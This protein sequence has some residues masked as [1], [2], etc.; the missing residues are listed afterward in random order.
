MLAFTFMTLFLSQSPC[1]IRSLAHVFIKGLPSTRA[2]QVKRVF[3]PPSAWLGR[4]LSTTLVVNYGHT[5]LTC[6]LL[7]HN[8]LFDA[9]RH[10]LYYTRRLSWSPA[11]IRRTFTAIKPE[12]WLGCP[13]FGGGIHNIFNWRRKLYIGHQSAGKTH[14]CG[15]LLPITGI[16]LL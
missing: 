5:P 15:I 12:H 16:L 10:Q 11:V 2:K 1:W 13:N 7:S 4:P 9:R 3:P 8:G 6:A 14:P